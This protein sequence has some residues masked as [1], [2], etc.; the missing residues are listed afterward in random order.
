MGAYKLGERGKKLHTYVSLS[1][2]Y[3]PVLTGDAIIAGEQ[4]GQESNLADKKKNIKRI[5][6]RRLALR[7]TV[8]ERK[9]DLQI[10]SYQ[11]PHS[12]PL[13]LH[14][15]IHASNMQPKALLPK[16]QAT[17]RTLQTHSTT[18]PYIERHFC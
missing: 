6:L 11:P 5:R 16:A 8:Y 3:V 14:C 4:N 9:T 1:K 15:T 10:H 13:H 18:N 12:I 2:M 7:S 17:F